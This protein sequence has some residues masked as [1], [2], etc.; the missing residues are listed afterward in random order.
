MFGEILHESMHRLPARRTCEPPRDWL[1]ATDSEGIN[2]LHGG[3]VSPAD[4]EK[5]FQRAGELF[6]VQ[7]SSAG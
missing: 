5:G 4:R 7:Q 2:R 1:Q 3:K 6:G